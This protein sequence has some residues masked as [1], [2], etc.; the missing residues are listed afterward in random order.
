MAKREPI[1]SAPPVLIP[2]HLAAD[3]PGDPAPPAPE[4]A[5]E[6]APPDLEP[7]PLAAGLLPLTPEEEVALAATPTPVNKLASRYVV[8]NAESESVEFGADAR[9][10]ILGPGRNIIG[11]N[12]DGSA[13]LNGV[14]CPGWSP[15]D[16]WKQAMNAFL[17]RRHSISF[18]EEEF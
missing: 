15:L 12:P 5:P 18:L 7:T 16:L 3:L 10:F 11:Q 13:W 14:D 2:A 8:V 6:V 9:V 4:E 1:Q 17:G